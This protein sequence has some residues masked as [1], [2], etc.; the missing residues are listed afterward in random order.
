MQRGGAFKEGLVGELRSRS[1]RIAVTAAISALLLLG[2]GSASAYA[3]IGEETTVLP[4]LDPLNRTENPLSNGGKWSP[5]SWASGT[6]SGRDTTTGWSPFDAFSTINGAY[7]NPAT[8]GD[9]TGN[10]AALT[11]Q[12]GPGAEERSVALWIDMPDPE[13]AKSGYQLKWT[14]NKDL[15]TYTA[16]LSK[17]VAGTSTE[18]AKNTSVTI[19]AGSTLAITDTGGSVT[20]WKGA[21]GATPTSLLSASDTT[22]SNGFA[23]L[24]GS[25]NG[26]RSI[27]FKAGTLAGGR[28]PAL[29]TLDQLT[30]NETPLSNGGS[31]VA[32]QWATGTNK[33]GRDT[34]SGWGPYAN[35]TTMNGAYLNSPTFSDAFGGDAVALTM[36]TAPG[37]V[38]HQV[39][40]WLNMPEPGVAKSGYQLRWEAQAAANTYTLKL[41]KWVGGTETVLASNGSFTIA[42]GTT[43]ALSDTGGKV[44]AWSGTG[45]ALN[46]AL[47]ASDSTYSSGS[48]GLSGTGENSRSINFK[49]G[50]LATAVPDTAL[51]G[52]PSG[53]VSP[54]VA[55]SF[56]SSPEGAT[57]QCS[58]DGAAYSSCTSP[59]YYGSLS[60][61]SHSFRVRAV[62]ASGYFD[63]S[64]VTRSFQVLDA[65]H[66]TPRIP[67]RDGL[68]R[69]E[70]PLT[71]AAWS[72]FFGA[73]EIGRTWKSTDQWG[74]GSSSGSLASAYWNTTKFSDSENGTF[75]SATV[76]SGA[77]P[78]GKYLALW[79]AA[80]NAGTERSGYEARFE[81]INGS[82]SNYKAEIAKWTA[83]VRTVL[84][85][86]TGVSLPEDKT[87][88]FTDSGR[89]LSL[90]SGSGA[91]FSLVLSIGD[92]AYSNGYAGVQ[93]SGVD[94]SLYDFRAGYLDVQA[95][96]TSFWNKEGEKFETKV[97]YITALSNESN[98]SFECSLDSAAWGPCPE[99]KA[100]GF[101]PGI[102]QLENLADGAHNLRT[103]AIDAGGNVDPTP[104]VLNFTVAVPP[105]TTITSKTP[106]FTS[107]EQPPPVTFTADDPGA[108]F[109]CSY[110]VA[111]VPT[112]A[113]TSPYNL[114][115][116]ITEGWHTFR[117]SGVDKNGYV[118]KT[119]AEYTFSTAI[120]PDAP[121]SFQ[122]VYPESGKRTASHYTLK[123][124]W[125]GWGVTGVTFQM[126][127]PAWDV[128]ETIPANCV[129]NGEG[130]QVSWPLVV[131]GYPGSTDS[132]FFDIGDCPVFSEAGYPEDV[133][134]RA[135]FDGTKE[136]SGAT[137]P[138][139]TEFVRS[140][141][142]TR[143]P[144]DA[145]ESIGPA[146]VDLLTGAF[147]VSRTD[148]S[149][150]VPG[151]E[152]NLEY[153]RVYN[154][155]W[156][157][158]GFSVGG[159]WQ[160][161][162][163]VEQGYEGS[164]WSSLEEKVIPAT[165][166]VYEKECW[167]EEGEEEC[168]EWLAEEA[169]PEV[170]WM[171]LLDNE[172]GGISF[173][174]NGS[175]YVS[176]DYAKE[177]K[178]TRE[179]ATHVVL[180]DPSGTHTTFIKN[181][182]GSKYL[183]KTISFQ[184]SPSS[185][186]MVYEDPGDSLGLRLIKMIG[187]A[188][189][190]VT[191]S[192]S[193]SIETAGCRTLE[194]EY[195]PRWDWSPT[196]GY[197][198]VL[199]ASIRYYNAS[200][201]KAASRVVA[202]YD[203][204]T[205]G[206][207]VEAWDPR[208]PAL[209]ETYTYEE[210]CFFCGFGLKLLSI[211]PAGEEPW[212]FHY[213]PE[214]LRRLTSVS[215]ASLFESEP[216]ATTS[217]VY[218][219]PVSGEDAPYDLSPP[220]I[221]EW[222]QVDYPVDATAIFPPTQVP[223]SSP[224][225][226][227]SQAIIHY[228]DPDGNEVNTASPAPPGVEGDVI[229][230]GEV[231]HHGNVVRSLSAGGRLEALKAADPFA[232][233]H[234]LDSHATYNG[235]GTRQLESWGPLHE[236]RLKNG[237]TV[238]ARAHTTTEYD[239]G[240]E[241]SA[242]EKEEGVTNWPNLPTKQTTGAA[243]SGQGKDA[244]VSIEETK[245]DWSLRKP[246]ETISDPTGLNLVEKSTY[247]SNGQAKTVSQPADTAG[248][249]AGTTKTVYWTATGSNPENSSCSGKAKWAGLP[250]VSYPVAD[251][252][253]AGSRPKLPWT[254]YTEYS[255]LDQPSKIEEKTNG[256][257]KRTTTF[258]YDS[259]GRP[260]VTRMTGEGTSVPAIETTYNEETGAAESQ[261]FVCESS[262]ASFD[263]QQ[264]RT[265][266]DSLGRPIRY[267]DADG[268]ESAV[269]YDLLGRPI[270][271]TDDKGYQAVA[272]DADSGV[273][274]EMTDSAAG[275]FKATYSP[276][277]QMTE[278]VLPN[279]LSQKVEYDSSGAPVRLEYTKQAGCSEG[280]TWLQFHR[281]NSI[282]GQVLRET[283][284]FG[285]HEYG[286]DAAGRL[287]LAKETPTGEGCTTRAYTFDK[288]TNRLSKTTRTPKAGGACDTESAGAKQSYEY[289]TADRLIGEGVEY[290]SLGRI[291]S[292]PATYSGGG[293]LTTT[294]FVNDLTR[295][296]TQD[297]ITNTYDLDASLRER[298]RTRT[299]GATSVYHYA[300]PGSDAPSWTQEG[301][302]WTRSIA[303]L[304]GSLGALQ[305]SNG[306]ITFQIADMHGD[307]I[308]TADKNP[309]ASELL[310][311]QRFDE[312][313]NPL[314]S[315]FLSGGNAEYGW[316][317]VNGR[318]TQLASGVIQM[319]VRSYVPALG[320]FLSRDPVPGGSA[321]AYDYADQDPVNQF[322]LTGECNLKK[323]RNCGAW[324]SWNKFRKKTERKARRHHTTKPIVKTC[325]YARYGWYCST[326]S[327]AS[328]GEI[329]ADV[330][331]W[332]G[333]TAANS[334]RQILNSTIILHAVN[335]HPT[336][337]PSLGEALLNEF[338]S[339]Q[340]SCIKG[341][342]ES[343][344]QIP[345]DIW[346]FGKKGRAAAWAWLAV[347]CFLGVEVQ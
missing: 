182:G 188:P 192:D 168:E 35:P 55:F 53:A 309:E 83:G 221:A 234:E 3:G 92:S 116:N 94:G 166:A 260:V 119:P 340:A 215:R 299:G 149:I 324:S 14:L 272:Y 144:T 201:S 330:R 127:L 197:S 147:T 312:F 2:L 243:I 183:P 18:L 332:A 308:A 180:T 64:P 280:C 139:A 230:T 314:Q 74:Y 79:L 287:T 124:R 251:P 226:D 21:A 240:F 347:G 214:S 81:G 103:R 89:R 344:V 258:E 12:T 185:V 175:S 231:D 62:D 281:E 58:M 118:D 37:A 112:T 128:F 31:W 80:P 176:P 218:G 244:D 49:A 259:A 73:A 72:K 160:P 66:A 152:A 174:I 203:Y 85:S 311:T 252:S 262:C 56:S 286:Y 256:V 44:A 140:L 316:L 333:K 291:T 261:Q 151:T 28:I 61:G 145:T 298:Q 276:N 253:P 296:Q 232:R 36:Q 217:I 306:E 42:P 239:K 165:L 148:V 319:G 285:T 95:P 101:G 246:V 191:C 322:D 249:T 237:E 93:A 184:A 29:G 235:D 129:R 334:V 321:N 59:K 156:V 96:E 120:Y 257:T 88:M 19:A 173:E 137:K 164:A 313:G 266:F 337:G 268:G 284:T 47:S 233:S 318:R 48:A 305:R 162:M 196:G 6:K 304:G 223:G 41:A 209:K 228:M 8:Y 126:K 122:L 278:Q 75:V 113:C 310:D 320:R 67:L 338:G 78:A 219:V 205:S 32:L 229:S 136:S 11:M 17:W 154:S 265:E 290:D 99:F 155:T 98:S 54:E 107:H 114:P 301:S 163:P 273:A 274:T 187:P 345:E 40:I 198:D 250:C 130:D 68:A 206:R 7:W 307:V 50:S 131:D 43:M 138:V 292:L 158:D 195:L 167:I 102:V 212:E 242:K 222:G 134:F 132:V 295:S 30:R 346:D 216:T 289:D 224:P 133:Q 135:T 325:G 323:K 91:S 171:E 110:D 264:T 141:N 179:D 341:I 248:T 220:T 331:G 279:G 199:L 247:N 57:F 60:E 263:Q 241:P 271:T 342:V 125:G 178:L 33:T 10:G 186:R 211:T 270:L 82:S 76:G 39:G 9:A 46:L 51:T 65:V 69:E 109:R 210:V 105:Q 77:E 315:G 108:K 159:L 34:T 269:A 16:T 317:G 22:Y 254:W 189:S 146:T 193:A 236:V 255:S 302:A 172:G 87:I 5:L 27:D 327:S 293:K 208:L 326:G 238:E 52:G 121:A 202:Q 157:S 336:S 70:N 181:G 143:I 303:A 24:E 288:D 177:L 225:S 213:E 117:V 294:Y 282:A 97:I 328:P 343:F 123:A 194:L 339:S 207:L 86:A 63:P 111:G 245:Y 170:R 45:S 329:W 84:T 15:S 200:G 190:G 297:G 1:A 100:E 38:G 227:Y 300:V 71:G 106:T 23:G 283:S 25:G 115:S 169:Q 104:A 20:A 26:S 150:S 153:T 277:K 204:D 4:V 13:A 275:T 142:G 335:G 267:F 90:W 161:S